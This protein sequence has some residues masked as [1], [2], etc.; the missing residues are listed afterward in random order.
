[1]NRVKK[2]KSYYSLLIIIIIFGI[3]DCASYSREVR[4]QLSG[5]AYC[6]ST[7]VIYKGETPTISQV[8]EFLNDPVLKS[9]YSP[10]AIKLAAAYGFAPEL[11]RHLELKLKLKKENKEPVPKEIA[12]E[13]P[14]ENKK[15]LKK[16]VKVED[17]VELKTK[18]TIVPEYNPELKELEIHILKRFNLITI[19][20]NS[21]AS[22]MNCY[23]DRF[24]EILSMMT[25]KEDDIVNSNTIFAIMSGA[26]AA[27]IDGLTIYDNNVNQKI[28]ISGGLLVSY[29]SYMAFRPM[30]TVEFRP[31]ST[32]LKDIWN[33]PDKTDNYSTAMWFL[34]TKKINEDDEPPYRELLIKRWVEN[35]FLGEEGE[36]REEM[37]NLF[38]GKGGIS[39]ITNLYNRREMI[40]QLRTIVTL[41]EQDARALIVEFMKD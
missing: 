40:T 37:V 28:I 12:K 1:M 36:E 27:I 30:V 14:I 9:R 21:L 35:N 10:K 17:L 34:M 24:T 18:A 25:E 33:N 8:R 29:F 39:S 20:I 7:N 23:V 15:E 6:V 38:F 26:I 5:A 2:I 11:K 13:T 41:Y 16:I 31:K 19:D 22:E 32:N 3:I 4:M